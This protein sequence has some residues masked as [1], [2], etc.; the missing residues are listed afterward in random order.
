[1]AVRRSGFS[2]AMRLVLNQATLALAVSLGRRTGLFETM[3][4]LPP[5]TAAGIAGAANLDPRYVREWLG[6]M[7][8]G[9]IVD[10]DGS[11]GTYLLPP[12]HAAV[13]TEA[14]GADDL[15][16]ALQA[17]TALAH[18]EDELARCFRTGAGLPAGSL[19]DWDG[20]QQELTARR[21]RASVVDEILPLAPGLVPRLTAGI[22]VLDVGGAGP[23]RVLL[24]RAFPGSRIAS[25]PPG[26][27]AGEAD[28][29][30][31]TALDHRHGQPPPVELLP[32]I[33]GRL[34]PRGVVLFSDAAGASDLADNVDHPLGPFLYTVSM[35]RPGARLGEAQARRRIAAA[36]LQ[37][38][39]LHRLEGDLDHVYY[40]A[41][42]PP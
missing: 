6:A 36:G 23:V 26:A 3:A 25:A 42:K 34:R 22:D 13:L 28:I 39:R 29:D 21:Q 7:V 41:T 40:L 17:V 11:K 27:L 38:V 20:L 35:F 24:R 14:A 2:Q 30:L 32:A 31:V 4:K 12:A 15:A 37:D 8:T 10:H 33:C 9:R 5:S 16:L 19:H 1:V 18:A